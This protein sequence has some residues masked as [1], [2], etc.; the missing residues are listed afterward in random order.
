MS[1]N[2]IIGII[3]AIVVV[4]G[5]VYVAANPEII[6]SITGGVAMDGEEM[7]ENGEGGAS[8]GQ[9]FAALLGLGQN[10][11][12]T[13]AHDDNAGNRSSGTV[14][15][16]DGGTRLAGDFMFEQSGVSPMEGHMIRTGGYNYVW[17]S[18]YP[19]GIKSQITAENE[20]ELFD[21]E[22]G[23][24][25]EDTEFH[26]QEWTVNNSKFTVP[27]NIQFMDMSAQMEAM[28]EASGSANVQAQQCAACNNL[29]AGAKEQCLAALAC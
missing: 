29:P 8:V 4:G 15:I 5:G 6:T 17:G 24:I 19:Q 1:T 25:D 7:M 12:C 10:L 26:C 23:G 9:T 16:A 11:E 21:S 13:F 27:T 18:F 22:D 14:Y 3:A 20:A 28:M 2:L